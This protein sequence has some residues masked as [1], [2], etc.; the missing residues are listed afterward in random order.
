MIKQGKIT[1]T[2]DVNPSPEE[3]AVAFATMGSDDQAEFFNAVAAE[4]EGWPNGMSSWV[5]QLQYIN[6]DEGLTDEARHIMETIGEYAHPVE[7]S[8]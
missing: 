4:V 5:M 6:T 7:A 1:R 3:L 8:K 2:I